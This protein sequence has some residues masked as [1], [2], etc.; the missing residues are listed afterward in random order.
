M[1]SS[2]LWGQLKRYRDKPFKILLPDKSEWQNEFN[3]NKKR[4]LSGIRTGPKL[5]KALVL[6]CI[7]GAQKRG[8]ASVLGSTPQYSR[9]KYML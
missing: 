4:A 3:P 9:Q 2:Y 6:E 5:M 7:G 1:N 8:I